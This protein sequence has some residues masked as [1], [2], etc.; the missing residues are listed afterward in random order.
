M[1]IFEIMQEQQKKFKFS[2]KGILYLNEFEVKEEPKKSKVNKKP[3]MLYKLE[4]SK[5]I[6]KKAKDEIN[7]AR[8]HG[9]SQFATYELGKDGVLEFVPASEIARRAKEEAEAKKQAEI[10]TLV[11]GEEAV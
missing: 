2:K 9:N 7:K 10:E 6:N 3:F 4:E 5:A 1:T 11:K 8:V